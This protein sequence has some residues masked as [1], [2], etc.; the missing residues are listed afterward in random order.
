MRRLG[1]RG[2]GAVGDALEG[3]GEAGR[4]GD[5]EAAEVLFAVFAGE[6][7]GEGGV[8][9]GGVGSRGSL[10]SRD[11]RV[12]R[13]FGQ[14]APFGPWLTLEEL[15]RRSDS[16]RAESQGVKV[17]ASLRRCRTGSGCR[18]AALGA[19]EVHV[20]VGEGGLGE[21]FE[22]DRDLAGLRVGGDGAG[23]A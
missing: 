9:G 21:V 7:E 17:A 23:R 15:A 8:G 19:E 20:E 12:G 6:V 4:S 3:G 22:G 2:V 10:R 13:P 14:G 11:G 5:F 16:E 1:D 18:G